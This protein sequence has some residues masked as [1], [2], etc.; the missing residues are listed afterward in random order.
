MATAVS[1]RPRQPTFS[2]IKGGVRVTGAELVSTLYGSVGFEAGSIELNPGLSNFPW[3]SQ[4]AAGWEKYKIRSFRVRYVPSQAVTT[5]AGSVYLGF[6]YDPDDPAP[7][8][9]SALSTYSSMADGRTFNS[10]ECVGD[11]QLMHD[12][13]QVKLIRNRPYAGGLRSHDAASIIYATMDM[14]DGTAIG[15]LWVDYEI[16]LVGRQTEPATFA[17][18]IATFTANVGATIPVSPGMSPI[19]TAFHLGFPATVDA[20]GNFITL[21]PGS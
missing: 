18:T 9:I 13:V 5:T 15:Q 10:F 12:G 17:K 20:S 2:S 21:P 7:A 6:D 14:I 16:D 19:W 3:L 4:Q 11:T 1:V 8:S